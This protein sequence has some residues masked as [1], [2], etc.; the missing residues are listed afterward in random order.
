VELVAAPALHWASALLLA[1]IFLPSAWSKLRASDEVT[2]IVADYR[3]LPEPLVEPFARGLPWVEIAAGLL[4]LA[5]PTRP[6]GALLA[7]G[8]LLLFALAMAINLA[9]GRREIDCGCFLGRQKERIGWPL[10]LRNLLLAAA[11]ALLLVE[12]AAL[13]PKPAEL[14]P[15]LFG[16]A[17]LLALYAAFSRLAGLAPIPRV[18]RGRRALADPHAHGGR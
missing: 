14:V 15:V 1:G 7:G 9:R 3:L 12:P 6:V 4:L 13:W 11:A 10:V 18:H 16:S 17:A 5:P 8:L 2:G